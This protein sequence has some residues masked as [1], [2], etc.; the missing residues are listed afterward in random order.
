LLLRGSDAESGVSIDQAPIPSAAVTASTQSGEVAPTESTRR[1][2]QEH[3]GAMALISDTLNRYAFAVDSLK[4]RMML[5]TFT[6]NARLEASGASNAPPHP[7]VGRAAIVDFILAGRRAQSDKRR[8]FVT[9]LWIE[10]LTDDRAVVHSYFMITI[11]GQAGVQLKSTGEYV[12]EMVREHD[13][14]WRTAIK[15]V[16]LDAP[17]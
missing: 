11:V 7:L 9:N 13:G 5:D 3:T 2:E 14:F 15:R 16:V 4:P 6:E 8:H 10:E 17:Y 12:D 1:A